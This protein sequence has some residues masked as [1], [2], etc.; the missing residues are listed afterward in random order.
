MNRIQRI[1]P[2][3]RDEWLALRT[4]DVTST[5]SAALFGLSPYLTNFELWH[6]KR[7]GEIHEI[8]ENE[9][10]IWGIRLQ[11][12]IAKGFAADQGWKVRKLNQYIRDSETRMG[13]SFDFEIIGHVD[14]PGIM[15]VKNVD[16]LAYRDGWV[17]EG[18]NIE[19]PPHIEIQVQHQLRVADRRWTM[20][21]ALVGGNQ[22]KATRRD[23]DNKIGELIL[24]KVADFW[25]SLDAG[26]PPEPNYV[27]DAR[28]ISRLYRDVAEGKVIDARQND[29]MA[30]LAAKYTAI[31]REAAAIND[32]KKAIKAELLTEIGDAEK[33][34]LS[35]ATISAKKVEATDIAYTRDGYRDFRVIP[36]REKTS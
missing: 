26:T 20:L 15:E 8:D 23:R 6:T 18:A 21:V 30:S 3:N 10:M 11:D 24:E 31:S 28:F 19:A 12:M 4:R 16:R 7:S 35:N 13:S 2:K 5:E 29:L 22:I 32:K 27:L 14:G 17:E 1:T 34:L 25:S 33:V 36:K 9:R